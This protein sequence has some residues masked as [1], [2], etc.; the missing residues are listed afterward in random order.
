MHLKRGHRVVCLFTSAPVEY[1]KVKLRTLTRRHHIFVFWRRLLFPACWCITRAQ[2]H[3]DVTYLPA[4]SQTCRIQS[5]S[6]IQ[7]HRKKKN[8]KSE[9]R[10]A[11]LDKDRVPPQGGVWFKYVRNCLLVWDSC[12]ISTA[13]WCP[14][15][16][17]S[18][19]VVTCTS[20][21]HSVSGVCPVWRFTY[22]HYWGFLWTNGLNRIFVGFVCLTAFLRD[23]SHNRCACV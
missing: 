3:A 21:A 6:W 4:L 7:G 9:S 13:N 20:A 22:F 8:L 12:T 14:V 10:S 11:L 1:G 18:L 19:L 17:A 15:T 5:V 2:V 16:N 23:Q